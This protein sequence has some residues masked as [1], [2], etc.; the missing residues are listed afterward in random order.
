[1]TEI[2]AA[3]VKQLR[4][5]TGVGIMDCKE[6]LSECDSDTD[7][8]ID[9]LR[10]KG[11]ATAQKRAGRGTSEG[12]IQAYI[13]TGGKIG[14]LV[15][16]NCETDFVAKNDDFKEFAKNMAM[17]I[18]ATNPVGISPEEVPQTIIE[19][20]KD[21]YRA[22]AREIGKP[23]KMIDKIA[24]GKL[25]KFYKDSCLLLQPYVR[26]PSVSIQDVLNDLIVKIGENIT[27]KRF[28]RL[29]I[30]EL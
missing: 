27:I 4:E 23:E 8:A 28:S 15:E 29:Q 12:L 3:M 25:N 24:E 22:Q 19:R 14:V 16:I 18:A 9:F 5:K 11:L 2:S 7:K 26:D 13:H 6:A 1:M 17:H 10:K 21:I 30:G 20:E